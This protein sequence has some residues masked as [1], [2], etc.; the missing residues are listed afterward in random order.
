MLLSSLAFLLTL[1]A[2]AAG[3]A[4]VVVA[5]RRVPAPVAPLASSLPPPPRLAP[6]SADP[7]GPG[8]DQKE[9]IRQI[10]PSHHSGRRPI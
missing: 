4:V 10:S 7:D 9:N 3:L 6:Q 8:A 5:L 2:P 1:A